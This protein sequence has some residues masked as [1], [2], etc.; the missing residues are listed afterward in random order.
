[1]TFQA[2][3]FKVFSQSSPNHII[4]AVTTKSCILVPISVLDRIA[5][6][7]MK[8]CDQQ[9]VGDEKVYLVYTFPYLSLSLKE[10]RT[11]SEAGIETEAM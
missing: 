5:I 6:V 4:G 7:M 1:M 3:S 10:F 11:R 9:Q 8:H 2:Q